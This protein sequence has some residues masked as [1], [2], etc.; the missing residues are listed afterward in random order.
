[1]LHAGLISQSGIFFFRVY[2]YIFTLE[3]IRSELN[4]LKN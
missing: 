2:F 4:E 1:M 3:T